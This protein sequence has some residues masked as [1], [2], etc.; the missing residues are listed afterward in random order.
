MTKSRYDHIL[1][2]MNARQLIRPKDLAEI[3]VPGQ[4]LNQMYKAG[5]VDRVDRGLYAPLNRQITENVHLAEITRKVPG[6]VVCLLSALR[7]YELTTQSPFETWVAI[8]RKA[9]KPVIN[10]PPTRF[11]TFSSACLM[12]GVEHHAITGVDIKVFSVEKTIADCFKYRN[13]IGTEVAIEALKE[14][15]V[16]RDL[17]RDALWQYS[18]LCRVEKVMRPYL[19]ALL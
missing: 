12:A 7:F 11:V 17:D 4:Y 14:G 18:K 13:K 2:L 9:R 16:E 6:G 10:Y 5:L 1:E 3:G 15:L 19:E 8:D